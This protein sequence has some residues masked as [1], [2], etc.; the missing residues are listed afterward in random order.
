MKNSEKP[1]ESAGIKR[2]RRA[3]SLLAEIFEQAGWRVEREP[4]RQ[5][6]QLDMIVRRP[7]VVYGVEVKA[8]VEGPGDRLVPLFA[9]PVLQP[10]RVRRQKAAPLA[11]VSAPKT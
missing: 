7:G 2:G 8:A 1:K 4:R 5:K 3:E 10:F 11:E 6:S 9:Q